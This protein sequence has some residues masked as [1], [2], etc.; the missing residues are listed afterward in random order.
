MSEVQKEQPIIDL[1]LHIEKKGLEFLSSPEIKLGP[2]KFWQ[3]L[4]I[5]R[6]KRIYSEPSPII[7]Y[8]KDS[9][10]KITDQNKMEIIETYLGVIRDIIKGLKHVEPRSSPMKP[11]IFLGHGRDLSWSRVYT[12]IKDDLGYNVEAFESKS[13]IS[14]HIVDVLKSILE[15]CDV[16][17]IV[18]S[19]EDETSQGTLR[20]RQN[21][22]HE[23][24][25]FQGKHGFEKVIVFQ[26]SGI[27]GF[28]NITGLQTVR[29]S[30]RP[31]DGFY[32]LER[33]I[34][35]ILQKN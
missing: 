17:V 30:S 9:R 35:M 34:N 33:A 8:V 15:N 28:S 3:Q 21:V 32:E 16:A 2:V 29:F 12:F 26:Q 10:D 24:G 19:A 14:S 7:S 27:E 22:I 5:H 4:V 31:E 18:M 11:T 6:L 1:L 23:I 20:A 25:L 13:R